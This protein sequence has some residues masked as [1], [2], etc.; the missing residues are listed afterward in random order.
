MAFLSICIPT[1]NRGYYLEN[2]LKSLI[3][4]ETFL[5]TDD[6]EI[7]ISDNCSFDNTEDVCKRFAELFPDKIKYYRQDKNVNDRN[8]IDILYKAEGTF[9]KLHNDNLFFMKGAL[10][11]IVDI[12]K[13]NQD[14]SLVFLT[15]EKLKNKKTEIEQY[16]NADDT[17]WNLSVKATWIGGLCVKT[18]VYNSVENPYRFS[19]LKLAQLDVLSRI[20]SEKVLIL[21][22]DLQSGQK[23]THKG[24][25]N[26][27]EVFGQNYLTILLQLLAEGYISSKTFNKL[28]KDVI[29]HINAYYFDSGK[30]YNFF[31]TGYFRYLLKYYKFCPYFYFEFL[32]ARIDVLF[33]NIFNFVYSCQK[34]EE[35]KKHIIFNIIKF[36]TKRKN[37][38]ITV[39]KYTYGAIKALFGSSDDSRLVIG[40][41]CSIAPDVKFIVSSEHNYKT[42]STY[43]FKVCVLGDEFEALSKGDIIVKDDV[44]I[45]ANSIILSGVTLNQGTVVAAGSV[46]TKDT[47]PYSIVG[48]NPAR[49]IKYRFSNKIIEKLLKVDYSNLD[50]DKISKN[51]NLLYKEINEEN[52]DK[53]IEVINEK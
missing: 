28:K 29:K 7:V 47:P 11:N 24:G 26:I 37:G 1:Y 45:G 48:G 4:D 12:L 30:K 34:N 14:S 23:I 3:K 42:I 20:I 16:T 49:V 46:V 41:F 33:K 25:Y 18:D 36:S 9:A 27:A 13:A 38:K 44:W 32:F 31:K 10:K 35:H 19:N 40:N 2:T 21:N 6:I 22:G 8:F 5:N 39:G 50:K 53:I 17:L 43:P 52:V 51:I 15:N